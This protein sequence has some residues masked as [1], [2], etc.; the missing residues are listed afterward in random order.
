MSGCQEGW[1]A[2]WKD[3]FLRKGATITHK[4]FRARLLMVLIVTVVFDL[5][6]A[7]I[8][9]QWAGGDQGTGFL[10]AFA[11]TTSQLVAGGSSYGV[12]SNWGHLVED[13][14]QVYGIT[15]VA[16][17]AGSFAAFFH[18]RHAERGTQRATGP[19]ET[20]GPGLPKSSA[21][22]EKRI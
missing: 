12:K 20:N 11:W 21:A 14:A 2:E 9:W 15:V 7:V 4:R 17:L 5:V 18:S 16:A 3:L 6:L 1:V 22:E 10:P 13:V 8:S 19:V